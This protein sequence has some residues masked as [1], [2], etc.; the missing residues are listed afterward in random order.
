MN[1]AKELLLTQQYSITE[2]AT[3]LGYCD[4]KYFGRKFKDFY[5]VCP[6]KYLEGITG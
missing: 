1:R 6:T 4:A 2:I 5:H 3:M